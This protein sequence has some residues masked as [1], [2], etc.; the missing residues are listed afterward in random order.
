MAIAEFTEPA[1]RQADFLGERIERC[2]PG[3]VVKLRAGE[4]S[5]AIWR[6]Q[7]RSAGR[8]GAPVAN[9]EPVAHD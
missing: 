1:A 9:H 5:R 7:R 2:D 3:A 8:S 4:G 6:A